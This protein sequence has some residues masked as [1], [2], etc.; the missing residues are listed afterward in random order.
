MIC[1]AAVQPAV[2]AVRTVRGLSRVENQILEAIVDQGLKKKT[3]PDLKILNVL[4]PFLPWCVPFVPV[5]TLGSSPLAPPGPSTIC[6]SS[7]F[8]SSGYV[9]FSVG[10]LFPIYIA[11]LFVIQ[12]IFQSVFPPF[13]LGRHFSF[14]SVPFWPFLGYLLL[15]LT[16]VY[17]TSRFITTSM[18]H[19][20]DPLFAGG[21]HSIWHEQLVSS[22]PPP[23]ILPPRP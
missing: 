15:T 23:K 11:L 21:K 20:S 16:P 5:P 18:F 6:P 2:R 12:R 17:L 1:S 19:L 14:P 9:H 8:P 10:T 4:G 3:F 13:I 22:S 7:A